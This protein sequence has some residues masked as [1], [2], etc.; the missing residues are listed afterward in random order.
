MSHASAAWGGPRNIAF[1]RKSPRDRRQEDAILTFRPLPHAKS[2]NFVLRWPAESDITSA[3]RRENPPLRPSCIALAFAARVAANGHCACG[4][5]SV[6]SGSSKD[7]ATQAVT[8]RTDVR[9]MSG[10]CPNWLGADQHGGVALGRSGDECPDR[11]RRCAVLL[12]RNDP[13]ISVP[14]AAA[15]AQQASNRPA[16]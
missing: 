4:F 14:R 7:F 3:A 13:R 10:L 15:I 1:G 11:Q 12:S 8:D 9:A 2:P 16:A 5:P 6:R